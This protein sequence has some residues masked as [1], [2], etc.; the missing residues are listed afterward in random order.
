MYGV[1]YA[2]YAVIY[3]MYGVIH[4]MYGAEEGNFGNAQTLAKVLNLGDRQFDIAVEG[5]ESWHGLF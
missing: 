3:V 1:I 5:C 4:V 2:M